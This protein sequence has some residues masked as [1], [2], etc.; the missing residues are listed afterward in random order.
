MKDRRHPVRFKETA[1]QVGAD[2]STDVFD[3]ILKP[4]ASVHDQPCER[5]LGRAMDA[6]KRAYG[7][8]RPAR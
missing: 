2:E 1:R 5:S 4:Q 8:I 3:P 6:R 7:A